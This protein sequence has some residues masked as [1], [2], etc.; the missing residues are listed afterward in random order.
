[1]A[2]SASTNEMSGSTH[3]EHDRLKSLG[4]YKIRKKL[5]AGGMGTVFLAV[6][7]QLNRTVALKVLPKERAENPTLVKRF[8]AEAKAAAQLEHKNIVRVYETGEL[9]GFLYIAL[10]YVDG[11]DVHE[12]VVKRDVI[13]VKRS[14]D[15]IKQVALALDHAASKNIV[16]R[17]IK[18]ANLMIKRDGTV[19]LA[20]MG[21]A[22]AV[23]DSLET[24]ITR[25]GMTVGTVDYMSPEQ[26]RSSQ[27]ADVRSDIYSLG[28]TWYHMLTGSP[29]FAEGGMT[30]KLQAHA[31][32]KRPDPRSVN[33]AVPEALVAVMHRMMARKPNDRY[34]TPRELLDDLEL[35][36]N[37]ASNIN[38]EV[39]E[40]LAAEADS[41]SINARSKPSSGAMP[42]LPPK[43][44]YKPVDLTSG[45]KLNV[46]VIRFAIPVVLVLVVAGIL[47]WATRE[48]ED[49][50]SGG[51]FS[52]NSVNPYSP[53]KELPPRPDVTENGEE[54]D[55]PADDPTPETN[56]LSG[57]SDLDD[58]VPG[59]VV[60]VPFPG[61]EDSKTTTDGVRLLPN[62]VDHFR[63]L[64][65]D[66]QQSLVVSREPT[67][68]GQFRQLNQAIS[69][70]PRGGGV[71]ELDGDGPFVL[72]PASI[73]S[74]GEVHLKA[75]YG[76]SPVVQ[77]ETESLNGT[78]PSFLQVK[79]SRLVIENLHFVMTD[80]PPNVT[81]LQIDEGDLSLQNCSVTVSGADDAVTTA[82]ALKSLPSRR[83][84]GPEQKPATGRCLLENVA[85]IGNGLTA[86]R[87]FGD[88]CELVAGNCL[89][90]SGDAPAIVLSD[91]G[92]TGAPKDGDHPSRR[93]RL[94]ASTLTSDRT[95]V[96]FIQNP[97]SAR[98]TNCEVAVRQSV[99]AKASRHASSAS[100]EPTIVDL[101]GWT[102][103]Q[104]D[105]GNS[106]AQ[107]IEWSTDSSRFVGWPT[108]VKF[109]NGEQLV[110]P[111]TNADE[112][113]RFWDKPLSSDT[114]V[115]A[116][117]TVIT[118][119]NQDGLNLTALVQSLDEIMQ[120]LAGSSAVGY[121]NG[122]LSMLPLGLVEHIIAAA[123]TPDD[124]NWLG[125]GLP[126]D[127]APIEIELSRK[128]DIGRLLSSSVVKDGSHVILTGS[129]LHE[130]TPVTIENKSLRV[131]FRSSGPPQFIL[132]IEPQRGAEA[133][134]NAAI[135][136][137]N[138]TLDLVR[139]RVKVLAS[140]S[141]QQPPWLFSLEDAS[142]SI[143][144]CTVEGPST[145]SESHSGLIQFAASENEAG[146]TPRGLLIENSFLIT[147]GQILSGGLAWET[148]VLRNNV[149][150]AQQDILDLEL[151][152]VG[153]LR[154]PA[155]VMEHCTFSTPQ[156][157]I[158]FR[159]SSIVGEDVPRL[160]MY[161]TDNLFIGSTGS[162]DSPSA[163]VLA[164]DSEETT[165]ARI[166]WWARRNA[167]AP[168]LADYLHTDGSGRSTE[169][170]KQQWLAAWGTGHEVNAMTEATDVIFQSI[171]PE[172][173][174]LG[175]KSFELS[176]SGRASHSALDG[177]PAGAILEHVGSEG[178]IAED[179]SGGSGN[180]TT[181]PRKR[182][183]GF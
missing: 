155:V 107:G 102:E 108:L 154:L 83:G 61:A 32:S 143:R 145:S 3:N 92:I 130:L 24:G 105:I 16:H 30:A 40:A 124:P 43:E 163:T 89:M 135:T 51:A 55:S 118:T 113:R 127:G 20:D 66:V 162:D 22:R 121:R 52:V 104:T 152:D 148:F 71:I 36:A 17:D 31:T 149:L 34:Q 13:P 169:S 15:I 27:A 136:V 41:G 144:G 159:G 81:I 88:A 4:K 139:A 129:G 23:D 165:Q 33:P 11:I 114:V 5:G 94:L 141:K 84:S 69:A 183:T 123:N 156:A 174:E 57:L 26:A 72:R 39:M 54:T 106:R 65:K 181:V 119:P 125:S 90:V 96:Q 117:P 179:T 64:P 150:V 153:L 175:P 172:W 28:C 128:R 42:A 46:D 19:K 10:E 109:S 7:Q 38:A 140:T 37:R 68:S 60:A 133:T 12:L 120:N 182:A 63:I 115:D 112:W 180:R 164:R 18:P 138:G 91:A 87:L 158:R 98:S 75:A 168:T 1:M 14:I 85:F 47:F 78:N 101:D 146:A 62:W 134:P 93:V 45:G 86:V 21:L 131:E 2:K 49:A 171:F 67:E 126:V 70:L 9:D 178:S 6:D 157:A 170:F 122:D 116:T 76:H 111:V 56:E 79:L 137:R 80:P 161:A 173:S 29:P 50:L 82:I 59:S 97:K 35:I 25:A 167:F 58:P 77:L 48:G 151:S 99:L 100:T 142:L 44:Q 132:Q 103:N 166:A 177:T 110:D 73:L 160:R 8:K 53:V 74:I 176:D 147:P 95:L